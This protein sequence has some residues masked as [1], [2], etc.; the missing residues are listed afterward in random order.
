MV[1]RKQI[2]EANHILITH[3]SSFAKSEKLYLPVKPYVKGHRVLQVTAIDEA[4]FP[5]VYVDL[6]NNKIGGKTYDAEI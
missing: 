4:G 5:S 3:N 1:D 6:T 2:V